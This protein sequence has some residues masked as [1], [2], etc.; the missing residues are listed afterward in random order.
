[1][2]E[3]S[4]AWKP[5]LIQLMSYDHFFW[6]TAKT[7]I[8]VVF[9][10]YLFAYIVCNVHVLWCRTGGKQ[11]LLIMITFGPLHAIP[12]IRW[13]LKHLENYMRNV[14][15]QVFY[16]IQKSYNRSQ[17]LLSIKVQFPHIFPMACWSCIPA[18]VLV[19]EVLCELAIVILRLILEVLQLLSFFSQ[20]L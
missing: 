17:V 19:N 8:F 18:L 12:S 11:E 3:V 15:N 10:S 1:M 16:C 6:R 20:Y 7:F 4:R 5:P 9:V 2:R 13:Q 14:E